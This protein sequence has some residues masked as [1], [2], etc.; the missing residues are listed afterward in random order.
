M[1]K[2][3]LNL[4][5]KKRYRGDIYCTELEDGSPVK[6]PYYIIRGLTKKPTLLIN[7]AIHGEELNGIEVVNRIFE[8][9]DPAALHGTIIG[10]PVVNALAFRARSRA[11]PIDNKNLNRVFPGKK[12]GTVTERIAYHFFHQIVKK[13]DFGIDLHTGMKGH[14][15][16]PHPRMRTLKDFTPSLEHHRAIGTELIFQNEGEK[17]MLNIEAGKIGIPIVCFEIGVA[18]VLDEY[19]IDAGLKGIMNFMK[20]YKLIEGDPEIPKQQVLLRDYQE[21]VSEM[22]G[23]F[24][25]KV[26]VGD[27]VK[28][29]QILG[30][31]KSPF[32]GDKIYSRAPRDCYVIGIRNQPVVR[33]G[34]SIAW[35][36]SFEQGKIL[37]K[38]RLNDLKNIS[39]KMIDQTNEKGIDIKE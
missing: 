7:A 5:I 22:G 33:Q 6:I 16:V 18:G 15:L 37:P 26:N 31:T 17:G 12:Y 36:M 34:T 28:K 29:N 13:V 21:V 4:G 27:V 23:L 38:I 8:K 24:Y 39:S 11:D 14:L 32:S 25:P 35:I 10:V 19:Y 20:F 2:I 3:N 9:I 1:E 30:I